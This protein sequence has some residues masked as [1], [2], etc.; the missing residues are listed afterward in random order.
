[1]QFFSG[2]WNTKLDEKGRFVLPS[3][4]R[5]GL[6]EQ[7]RLEIFLGLSLGGCL[8]IY[9]ESDVAKMVER[10]RAKQHLAR[11]QSL[12]TTFFSSLH[13]ALP[14]RV[15]RISLPPLLQKVANIGKKEE[16]TLVGVIDKIE[17]L[18]RAVHEERMRHFLE[19]GR[20]SSL[21]EELFSLLEPEKPL[22]ADMPLSEETQEL[23]EVPL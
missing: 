5:D 23:V 14:D 19:E 16:L 13:R 7:G 20:S 21:C 17:I 11:Y 4:L 8:A 15:G 18:P 1:M 9:R 6:V 22:K 2:S 10:F 12:F 3:A